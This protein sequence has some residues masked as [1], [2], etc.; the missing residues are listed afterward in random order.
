MES[1]VATGITEWIEAQVDEAVRVQQSVRGMAPRLAA[2]A[3]RMADVLRSGGRVY[4][5]GNGGSAADA[6]HWAAELSGKFYQER[7]CL[8]AIALTTNTSQLTA[9]AN[10]FGYDE[11]FARPL[12]GIGRTGDMAVGISTSGRSRNVVRGMQQAREIGMATV[13]MT[14]RSE[15]DMGAYCDFLFQM[16]TGDVAR[17]QEGHEVCGHIICA[18]VERMLFGQD[19]ADEGPTWNE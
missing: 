16:P 5:F 4:F 6:Q 15:G 11:I 14:G 8:P 2:C 3:A 13:G 9:L 7:A 1:L 10:D 19:N 18:A 12:A 17:I